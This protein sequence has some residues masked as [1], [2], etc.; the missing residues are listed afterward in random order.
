[1]DMYAV[2]F[3]FYYTNLAMGLALPVVVALIG[4]SASGKSE[5]R[6]FWHGVRDHRAA[7]LMLLAWFFA[8]LAAWVGGLINYDLPG[9]RPQIS[10]LNMIRWPFPED[11][12]NEL[13]FQT[14]LPFLAGMLAAWWRSTSPGTVSRVAS[15]RSAGV[16]VGI[17]SLTALILGLVGLYVLASYILG[18][19]LNLGEIFFTGPYL[20]Y[21]FVVVPG[22]ALLGLLG[23]LVGG[24]AA[25]VGRRA[26]ER[27][28]LRRPA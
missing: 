19:P 10:F 17:V 14:S 20:G 16:I 27:R 26:G 4:L 9:D 18:Q 11:M 3:V 23:C 7:A 24:L 25:M 22:G 6:A 15:G 5:L 2:I 1:M 28:R 13:F 12:L 21:A 8:I